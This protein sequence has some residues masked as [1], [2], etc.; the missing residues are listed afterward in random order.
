MK[1][2]PTIPIDEVMSQIIDRLDREEHEQFVQAGIAQCLKERAERGQQ[3][4]ETEKEE[5]SFH[6]PPTK[7]RG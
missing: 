4:K 3:A 2:M 1:T 6:A 7:A 5:I